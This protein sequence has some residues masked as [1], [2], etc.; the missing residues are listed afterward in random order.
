MRIDHVVINTYPTNVPLNASYLSVK[1][2]KVKEI[3][4]V[5][6]LNTLIG[7]SVAA[8]ALPHHCK[9]LMSTHNKALKNYLIRAE[10]ALSLKLK[11]EWSR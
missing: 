1:N 7:H 11:S 8:L 9:N 2:G 10:M 5:S 4:P 3:W 6:R